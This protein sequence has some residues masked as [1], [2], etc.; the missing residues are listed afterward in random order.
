MRSRRCA[1]HRPRVF[2]HSPLIEASL[3]AVCRPTTATT[4]SHDDD[5]DDDGGDDEPA[6]VFRAAFF[7]VDD[8][9]CASGAWRINTTHKK[10]ASRRATATSDG[11]ER[12]EK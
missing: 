1:R 5:N 11:D 3:A 2:R 8:K 10:L 4:G 12:K 9:Q 6:I 7:G